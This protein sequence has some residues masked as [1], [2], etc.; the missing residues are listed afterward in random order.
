M[1]FGIVG[2]G[3]WSQTFNATRVIPGVFAIASNAGASRLGEPVSPAP[4]AWQEAQLCC[5]YLRPSAGSP[6]S[7]APILDAGAAGGGAT[8]AA[9][10]SMITIPEAR[11]NLL[12]MVGSV[13]RSWVRRNLKDLYDRPSRPRVA[14]R[15]SSRMDFSLGKLA[16]QPLA[17]A[18]GRNDPGHI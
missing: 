17:R 18:G 1:R 2:C 5:A 16:D 7:A 9:V 10:A 4:T 15:A 14:A 3:V 12:R 11:R 13:R 8:H 6:I